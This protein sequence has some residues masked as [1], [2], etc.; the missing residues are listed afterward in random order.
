MNFLT[1]EKFNHHSKTNRFKRFLIASILLVVPVM[2]VAA[3]LWFGFVSS[4]MI[5]AATGINK[6]ITYQGKLA[7]SSGSSVSSGTMALSLNYMI[8]LLQ[9][10]YYGQSIGHLLLLQE[11]LVYLM[12]SLVYRLVPPLHYLL[13]ISILIHFTYKFTLIVMAMVS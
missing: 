10:V 6:Q 12:V 9:V 3:W 13:L 1:I 2:T 8:L 4:E 5:Q 11:Q 7:D